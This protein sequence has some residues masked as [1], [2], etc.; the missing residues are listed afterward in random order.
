MPVIE[1]KWLHADGSVSI[2][3]RCGEPGTPRRGCLHDG[4]GAIGVGGAIIRSGH[5]CVLG[6]ESGS[7]WHGGYHGGTGATGADGKVTGSE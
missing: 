7:R 6:S 2:Y 4:I 5:I 3:V 1:M